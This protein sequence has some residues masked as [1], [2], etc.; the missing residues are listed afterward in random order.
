MQDATFDQLFP[1]SHR[2]RSYLHWTPV[3]VAMRAVALLSPTP[4]CKV[5][6]VGAGVGKLCLIGAALTHAT[7]FGVER[8]AEMVRVA[9]LAAARLR[10]E[11]RTQFLHGDASSINWS[12]FDAFYLF[13]PFAEILAYGPDD[14]LTRRERYVAAIDFVQRQLSRSAAGTRVVTYH[15]FGG[16]LLPAFDLVHRETA[17]EDELCLWVRRPSRRR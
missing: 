15:G 16:E 17:R 13:N 4:R 11:R 14:A 5:L 12:M 9:T 7:W 10:V 2:F 6:D 8:D 1:T 3:D